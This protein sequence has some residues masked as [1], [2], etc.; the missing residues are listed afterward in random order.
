M[1]FII[2]SSLE[3][4]GGVCFLPPSSLSRLAPPHTVCC[5]GSGVRSF[6]QR[7]GRAGGSSRAAGPEAR[8]EILFSSEA[9]GFQQQKENRPRGAK[10]DV[11]YRDWILEMAS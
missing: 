5:V 4:P 1:N 6:G 10:F 9:T 8:L 2:S 7:D 3:C 11:S